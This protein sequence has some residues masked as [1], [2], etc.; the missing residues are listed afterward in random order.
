MIRWMFRDMV[1]IIG[2]LFTKNKSTTKSMVVFRSLIF[3]GTV[4]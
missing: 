1:I 3:L 2:T 4:R